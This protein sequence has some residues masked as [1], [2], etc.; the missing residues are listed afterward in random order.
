MLKIEIIR[1]TCTIRNGS[2]A[3]VGLP[4]Q[5]ARVVVRVRGVVAVGGGRALHDGVGRARRRV[6]HPAARPAP[7]VLRLVARVAVVLQPLLA[8][9][10]TQESKRS[11]INRTSPKFFGNKYAIRSSR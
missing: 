3:E 8:Y 5:L 1:I 6:V 9:N 4:G 7:R 11:T 10:S 2:G